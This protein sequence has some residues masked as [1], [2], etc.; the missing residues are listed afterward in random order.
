LL[1]LAG[2]AQPRTPLADT[3]FVCDGSVPHDDP[4]DGVLDVVPAFGVTAVH[5]D[6]A[7]ITAEVVAEWL[8][9]GG[10]G[11]AGEAAGRFVEIPVLYDGPDLAEV[12][13]GLSADEVV[14]RHAEAEYTVGAVGFQPGF[15]YLQ[16]LPPELHTPRKASPRTRVALCRRPSDGCRSVRC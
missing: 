16:G 2:V 7:W 6:P 1:T 5:F 15:G 13:N 9:G 8:A 4:P 12:G 14:R 10:G 11:S 3:A